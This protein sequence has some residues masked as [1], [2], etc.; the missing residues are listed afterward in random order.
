MP[1]IFISFAAFSISCF[2]C[3]SICFKIILHFILPIILPIVKPYI[4][5]TR[6][7]IAFIGKRI[8]LI[9]AL[10][11][12]LMNFANTVS[13]FLSNLPTV[14]LY[15]INPSAIPIYTHPRNT[16]PLILYVSRI[17]ADA[18]TR[19]NTR[20]V[21]NR[22]TVSAILLIPSPSISIL[23]IRTASYESPSAVPVKIA[24]NISEKIS[25]CE[26]SIN[27]SHLTLIHR[28][29]KTIRAFPTVCFRNNI[30]R[31]SARLSRPFRQLYSTP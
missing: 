17:A 18:P 5:Q 20:S 12:F 14:N 29:S 21:K 24:L 19:Q 6:E 13:N 9:T 15:N 31:L 11:V 23:H 1:L 26:R 27:I 16:P 8:S 4:L 28:V 2:L 30:L 10:S 22:N 7:K 3:F 25:S